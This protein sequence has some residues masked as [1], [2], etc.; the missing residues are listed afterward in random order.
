[1]PELHSRAARWTVPLVVAALGLS[2][3]AEPEDD[4]AKRIHRGDAACC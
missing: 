3:C 4:A 2:A 1:M